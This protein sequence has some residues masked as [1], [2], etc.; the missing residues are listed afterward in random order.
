MARRVNRIAF[1]NTEGELETI[2]PDGSER[3]VL[4]RG[5][6]FFQFPAWSPDGKRIAAIGGSRERASGLDTAGVFLF[7]DEDVDP[8]IGLHEP[9]AVYESDHNAP[10]YLYWSPDSRHLS[11]ITNR[12]EEQSLAFHVASTGE[13]AHL[14]TGL[15]DSDNFSPPLVIGRPCFW[16]W[17]SDSKRILLHVG[18]A[19]EDDARLMFIDPFNPGSSRANIAQ[20]GLFQAPGI[21][22]SGLYW[23]FAQINRSGELQLVVDGRATNN[24]M[25][26]SHQGVA[27]MSWSPTRDQLA[28]I[29]PTE[30]VRACYGPLRVLDAATGKIQILT[31]E[32]VLAFFWSP[33][34]RAIAY[35]TVAIIADQ[36][37]SSIIPNPRA[38]SRDGGFFS[39]DTPDESDETEIDEPRALRLNVWVVNLDGAGAPRGEHRLLHTFEPIDIFVNQF[40]PFF[41]QYALSHRIWSPD[42]NALM[43]PMV[44]RAESG[45]VRA[46][47]FVVPAS[48]RAGRPYPIAEGVMAFWS[49]Q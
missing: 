30:P 34:G 14:E 43:L 20:P 3:R 18:F 25:L 8:G 27:A 23:A 7:D 13:A 17:T 22:R 29:S 35:F 46:R 5:S 16:D 15:T 38:A 39:K 4:S 21:A 31:D 47:I 45:D 44:D 33:D 49:H 1:I 2:S 28:Y 42:S 48:R 37:R 6:R 9:E 40:L 10:I 19:N 26:V 36:I 32:I 24:R 12:V 11:F 41:D